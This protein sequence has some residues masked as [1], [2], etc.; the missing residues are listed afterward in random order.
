MTNRAL[1]L[2]ALSDGPSAIRHPLRAR[3]TRLMADALQ[4]LGTSVVDVDDGWLITPVPM[5]GPAEIDCGLAGTVM[6]FLP[7]LAA[8]AEGVVRFDGDPPA[9]QRPMRALLRALAE[10]GVGVDDGGRGALP[11]VV[12]GRGRVAGGAVTI[13]ASAS[14]QY[15]SGLLLAGARYERGLTVQH[16]GDPLPSEPHVEMTVAML[17]RAG[18]AVSEQPSVWRVE[19]GPIGPFHVDIEPDLSNA[20]PFLAAAL[21]TGGSVVVPSW[22]ER[23][24][25]PGKALPGLLTGLGGTCRLDATGLSVRGVGRIRGIDVDLHAAG[26]LTPVLA[27]V[28]ALADSPSRLRGIAHLRGHETDRLTALAAELTALGG[29]VEQFDDGL[30]IRPRPLTGGVFRTYADHRMAQAGAVLGLAV[31][32]IEVDDVA[33]TAKTLPDFVRRWMR[34]LGDGVGGPHARAS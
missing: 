29:D 23:T 25:Q 27:A 26:E 14:S 10:L 20:A 32:G 7:P 4:A 16:V 1:V 19:P 2:A 9:R 21:V 30:T 12:H 33:T 28:A 24:T 8:L 11:F 31:D 13:D 6:R 5:R 17:R 22:P 34:M 18:V 15:V 3:D